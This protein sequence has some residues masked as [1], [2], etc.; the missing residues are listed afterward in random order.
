MKRQSMKISYWRVL[1]PLTITMIL[2]NVVE[3]KHRNTLYRIDA[4]IL[5]EVAKYLQLKLK[6]A[7]IG[8]LQT[9]KFDE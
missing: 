9:T 2:S 8:A 4:L 5:T 7:K 1:N 3:Q 6:H